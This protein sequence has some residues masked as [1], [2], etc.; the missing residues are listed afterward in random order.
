M[1]AVRSVHLR[2]MILT[3]VLT[4][5]EKRR[6]VLKMHSSGVLLSAACR[7][8][9]QAARDVELVT[10]WFMMKKSWQVGQQMIQISIPHVHSVAIYFCL[11]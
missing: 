11:F 7:S 6:V 8:L 4:A 1:Q 3:I 5:L 10:V 9:S 2:T